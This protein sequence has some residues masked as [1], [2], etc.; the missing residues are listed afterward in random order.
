MLKKDCIYFNKNL[1]DCFIHQ[2]FF[3]CEI[4]NDYEEVIKLD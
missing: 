2:S 1:N 4:C 3:N